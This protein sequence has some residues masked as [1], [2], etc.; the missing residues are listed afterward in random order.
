MHILTIHNNYQIRGGE[1]VSREAEERLLRERGHQ[2]ESYEDDN[3][4][5]SELGAIDVAT[6]TLWSREAYQQVKQKLQAGS[7]DIVHVQNFFPLISPSVYYAAQEC[8]VPVV[9]TLR[10]YRLL[11]PNALFFRDG[12]VCEDCLGKV[13]P[14]PGVVHR[15]YRQSRSAS[16]ATA[17]MLVVH[18][19]LQT[20]E[21][22]VD[23]YIAL[24]EF[25]RQKFIEGGLSAEKIVVK[26]NFVA[27]D[28]GSGS[29]SGGY[30]LYVG[31]LSV[32]KGL[33]VLLAAWERL[34]G[35]V[36]LKIVG[37]GP[38]GDRVAAAAAKMPEVEWL[39]RQPMEEVHRLMGEAMVLVFPSKWYE[40]FGRVAVEAFAKGT[41]AIA[42]NLGAIAE[43]VEDGRTGIRFQPSDPVDLAAKVEWILN[44][45]EPLAAMRRQARA[46]Y[47]AKYTPDRNYEQLMAIYEGV[48][49]R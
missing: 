3:T 36:R 7:Y 39:G 9:Q 35:K 45:P 34:G 29:G 30:A 21:K 25:A 11:C 24:T 47:L 17:A 32:E 33:D 2:V 8:G 16:A 46:E 40:T 26:P 27:P 42:A 41:P 43:L 12:R 1:E 31:R 38:W 4:R 18:R 20:W 13:I 15:C 28:P 49:R 44:H 5:L 48:R 37:D 14:W 22:K 23:R 19:G 6:R 10:N